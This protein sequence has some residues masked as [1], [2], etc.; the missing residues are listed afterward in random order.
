MSVPSFTLEENDKE[1]EKSSVDQSFSHRCYR[2]LTEVTI[3]LSEVS[4]SHVLIGCHSDS[5]SH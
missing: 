1:I 5:C 2:Y 4:G 3:I